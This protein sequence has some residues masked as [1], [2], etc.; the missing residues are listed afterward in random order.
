MDT[1]STVYQ[2]GDARFDLAGRFLGYPLSETGD[3]ISEGLKQRLARY[4][5][6]RIT[7]L[8]LFPSN[9]QTCNVSTMDADRPPSERGYQVDFVIEEGGTIGV[10]GILTKHGWPTLDHGLHVEE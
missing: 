10:S 8:G 2:R 5:E 3:A 4:A 6:K 1:V 7:E 9:V